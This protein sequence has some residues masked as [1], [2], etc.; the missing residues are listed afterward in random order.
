MI[1]TL[2]DLLI[3]ALAYVCAKYIA[4]KL[5]GVLKSIVAQFFA[6]LVSWLCGGILALLLINSLLN[7][8][9]LGEIS[10]NA[11]PTFFA[12]TFW[13]AFLGM[14]FGI[15]RGRKSRKLSASVSEN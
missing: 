5:S 14:L 3:F 12:R 8:L 10:H 13:W 4:A 1:V 6:F 2:G 15:Y 7:V 9:Q 11:T